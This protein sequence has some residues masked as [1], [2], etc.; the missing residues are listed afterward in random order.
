VPAKIASASDGYAESRDGTSI[1]VSTAAWKGGLRQSLTV[2]RSGNRTG[3]A[4]GAGKGFA[5]M[6]AGT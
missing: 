1:V 2:G 3:G 5:L 6:F 4:S